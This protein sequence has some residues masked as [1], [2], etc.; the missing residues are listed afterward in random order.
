[1]RCACGLLL[2]QAV[3]EHEARTYVKRSSPA[4]SGRKLAQCA[5]CGR[6]R[7]VPSSNAKTVDVDTQF[8]APRQ[9]VSVVEMVLNGPVEAPT[10]LVKAGSVICWY[11]KAASDG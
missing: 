9:H 8:I 4:V 10:V 3:Y 7:M 6:R 2:H 11:H 1:M 5:I